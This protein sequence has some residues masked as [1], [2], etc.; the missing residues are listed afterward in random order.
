MCL[1]LYLKKFIYLPCFPL[2]CF[3]SLGVVNYQTA[4]AEVHRSLS[5]VFLRIRVHSTVAHNAVDQRKDQDGCF[6]KG[7]RS[8]LAGFDTFRKGAG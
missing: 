7:D 3:F 1:L 4:A 2:L 5:Q 6:L 8:K